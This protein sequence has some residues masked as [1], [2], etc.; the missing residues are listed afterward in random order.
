[1]HEENNEFEFGY[2]EKFDKLNDFHTITVN[3]NCIS[4]FL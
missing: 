4:G 1:M 3:D 2:M